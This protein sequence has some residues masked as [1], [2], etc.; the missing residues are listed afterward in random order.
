[1]ITK[2]IDTP[3]HI[4]YHYEKEWKMVKNRFLK[5]SWTAEDAAKKL[6]TQWKKT[7]EPTKKPAAKKVETPEP[8]RPTATRQ[9]K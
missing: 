9:N 1:M 4:V 6:E 2:T 5:G 7:Y 3:D 8:T